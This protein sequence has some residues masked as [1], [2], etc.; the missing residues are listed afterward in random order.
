VIKLKLKSGSAIAGIAILSRTR[1]FGVEK[2]YFSRRL[3]S[4][5]DDCVASRA[6]RTEDF[7]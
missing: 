2:Y 1:T 7:F 4:R 6:V 3:A 5:N